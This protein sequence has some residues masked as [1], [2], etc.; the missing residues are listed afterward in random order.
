LVYAIGCMIKQTVSTSILSSA[1]DDSVEDELA[2]PACRLVLQCPAKINLLLSVGVL[3]SDG[4]H[5]V[6]SVM[7]AITLWDKL[8]IEPLQGIVNDDEQTSRFWFKCAHPQLSNLAEDNLV[9]KAYRAFWTA[10]GLPPLPLAVVLDKLIPIQ[11]GLGG[12]SA[13]AAG[14]LLALNHLT[15]QA[16]THQQNMA[17]GATL[18][19]DIPFFMALNQST[20][21]AAL[22]T[23][24][25][26]HVTPLPYRLP[27]MPL[28]IIQPKNFGVSTQQ[29]YQQLDAYRH[30]QTL[31]ETSSSPPSPEALQQAMA[32]VRYTTDYPKLEP[33]LWNDFQP[34]MEAR[35]PLLADIA[36]RMRY[37]GINRPLLCGSGSAYCGFF[38]PSYPNKQAISRVFLAK[39]YHVH[40]VKLHP[41]GLL[42]E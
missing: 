19:S 8:T 11:A 41:S 6:T 30:A 39:D 18:G 23:G 24:R 38:P 27:R 17:L 2:T 42:S 3:Q 20:G 25:G 22:A 29:A 4:Y 31:P 21:G 9:A 10:T 35:Y 34:V 7:H 5:G 15:L 16:L 13:N 33:Y 26:D 40:W 28:V 1:S 37:V 12:G 36:Q 32:S 14:M